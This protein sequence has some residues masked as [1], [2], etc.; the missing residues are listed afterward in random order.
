MATFRPSVR[1]D[2]APL[3][4]VMVHEPGDEFTDVVDPD[5]WGWRG[6][7]RQKEAV[8]E[9]TAFVDQLED[10]GVE[11][12]YLGE[13][14]GGLAESLFVRDVGFVIEGGVVVGNMHEAIRDG[15]EHI[16]TERAVEMGLPVYHTVHGPGRFEAGN[17]V[18]LDEETVAVGRS[19]TTNAEGIRQVRGVLTTYGIELVEVP[20]FGST[21]SSGQTHLALVFGMVD[22]DLALVYSQAVPTEFLDLLHDRGIE[23]IDVPRRE[24]RKMATSSVVLS[25]GTVLLAGGNRETRRALDVRGVEIIVAEISEIRKARGGLKGLVLPLKRRMN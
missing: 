22:T 20:I 14:A 18:W 10:H 25:P 4:H 9:H 2:V 6:L 12:H 15:E 5:A 16:L 8:K 3:E 24:Q 7:P 13:V 1:S 17:M 19:M 21:E 11:I 23:T